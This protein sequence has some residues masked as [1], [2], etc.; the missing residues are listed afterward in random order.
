MGDYSR[1]E[2][3]GEGGCAGLDE[4]PVSGHMHI[5]NVARKIDTTRRRRCANCLIERLRQSYPSA[6]SLT[7]VIPSQ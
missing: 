1:G 5:S 6:G 2:G 7:L 3:E 4:V